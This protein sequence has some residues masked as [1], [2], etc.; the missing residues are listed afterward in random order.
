MNFARRTRRNDYY[1][2]VSDFVLSDPRQ[3]IPSPRRTPLQIPHQIHA[4]DVSYYLSGLELWLLLPSLDHLFCFCLTNLGINSQQLTIDNRY[5]G[6]RAFSL[7][8]N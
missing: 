7:L 4:N 3:V 1:L 8:R 5:L 6:R 2:D